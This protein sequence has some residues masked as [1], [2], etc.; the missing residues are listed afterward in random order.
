MEDITV[1][2]L[3]VKS[4]GI[5]LQQWCVL[6]SGTFEDFNS[7]TVGWGAM[8]GMWKRPFVQV[9]VRPGRHTFQYME[10]YPTFTLCA[11]PENRKGALTILGTKS[12]RDS[13]KITESGLTVVKSKIV[14]APAY[15]EAELIL[16]C[17]KMYWQDMN[18]ENFLND[19]IKEN[20]PQ[21]DYHR[22]YYGE[23][24]RAAG[25]TTYRG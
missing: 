4:A 24:V 8:G 10:K 12:G 5:W 23:I 20:Y 15:K 25:E 11:F 16:E 22:I 9:V 1:E 7:M 13:D 6:T 17:R 21:K 14:E 19:A 2:T 18:P 3:Q